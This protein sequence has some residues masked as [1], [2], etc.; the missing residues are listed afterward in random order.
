M[1]IKNGVTLHV[2]FFLHE[3]FFKFAFGVYF[4]AP[5][6]V[7]RVTQSCSDGRLLFHYIIIDD[8][9]A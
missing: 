9:L 5:A 6:C 8:C 4:T 2:G 1:N 3:S 7:K